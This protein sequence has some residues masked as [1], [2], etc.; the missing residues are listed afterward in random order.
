[1]RVAEYAIGAAIAE[2]IEQLDQGLAVAVNIAYQ[3]ICHELIVRLRS[4]SCR[5]RITP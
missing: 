4:F 3:I 2:L 5:L 1:M